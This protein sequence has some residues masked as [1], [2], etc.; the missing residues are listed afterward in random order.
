MFVTSGTQ[1]DERLSS[2]AE[3]IDTR[4]WLHV[5]HSE[6]TRKLVLSPDTVCITSG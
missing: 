3:E 5:I 1:P 6:G 2:N 4:I